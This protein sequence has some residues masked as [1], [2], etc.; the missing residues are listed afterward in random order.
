MTT[1]RAL[2]ALVGILLTST[3][4]AG[5]AAAGDVDAQC[6][7][8]PP[9]CGQATVSSCFGG[10]VQASGESSVLVDWRVSWDHVNGFEHVDGDTETIE[11]TRVMQYTDGSPVVFVVP[12]VVHLTVDVRGANATGSSSW[13]PLAEAQQGCM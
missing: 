9:V 3:L 1:Q 10:P 6:I 8:L 4:V 11:D 12:S 5:P 13:I 7:I 2:L